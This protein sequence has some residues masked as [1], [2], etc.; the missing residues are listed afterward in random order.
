MYYVCTCVMRKM[1]IQRA[2]LQNNVDTNGMKSEKN[3]FS[4]IK[5]G[6]TVKS[7]S[8]FLDVGMQKMDDN[9]MFLD[10]RSHFFEAESGAAV[11]AFPSDLLSC[12]GIGIRPLSS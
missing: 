6:P 11:V 12:F 7:G 5:K 3:A 8:I 1:L 9:T 4:G 10:C 2:K